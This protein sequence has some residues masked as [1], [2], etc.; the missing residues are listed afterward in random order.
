MLTDMVIGG[1]ARSSWWCKALTVLS[2]LR[3]LRL[4]LDLR[5]RDLEGLAKL[6]KEVGP[7]WENKVI[8]VWVSPASLRLARSLFL[9]RLS[10]FV[11]PIGYPSITAHYTANYTD[12]WQHWW[13]NPEDVTLYQFMG[14]V[15]QPVFPL[16]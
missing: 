16:V 11:A 5:S 15:S 12:E 2:L 13:R 4:A 7:K 10:Q 8:Y 6:S 3:F 14:K 1:E 9:T